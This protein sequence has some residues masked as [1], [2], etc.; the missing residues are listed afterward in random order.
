MASIGR[1]Q[2]MAILQAARAYV[3]GLNL[4]EA[5]SWGLNRAIFYAAAKKGYFRKSKPPGRKIHL[6]E[7]LKKPLEKEREFFYLGDEGAYFVETPHGVRFKIGNK[8]QRPEDF[9]HQIA[10]KFWP[11]FNEI[12]DEAIKIVSEHPKDILL[13]QRQFFKKVYEPLR[14]V[15]KERWS[16]KVAEA[17]ARKT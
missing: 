3:L 8:V 9:D 4:D 7:I 2:V 6:E 17:R 12:W 11:I 15:L 5:K 14:D 13:S 1:F 16:R 10:S